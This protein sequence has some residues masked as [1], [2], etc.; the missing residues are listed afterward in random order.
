MAINNLLA[1]K[2]FMLFSPIFM[3]YLTLTQPLRYRAAGHRDESRLCFAKG[4]LF[5]VAYGQRHL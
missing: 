4:R 1:A 3:V 2:F 5:T